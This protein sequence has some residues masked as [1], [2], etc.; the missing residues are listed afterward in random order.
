MKRIALT[1][2]LGALLP[3]SV[4]GQQ[5]PADLILLNG[6]IFTANSVQPYAQAVAIRGERIIA[7]GTSVDIKS[8]TGVKTRLI[9]L[10]G[11]VV[12]P[13]IND[14]HFHF[15]PDPKGYTLQF[16][17]MNP[18][19]KEAVDAIETAVKQT[20]QGTWIFGDLGL[21]EKPGPEA[22][23]FA[24]DRIAA[25]NPVLLR[26]DGHGY[27]IN[28]KAMPLLHIA[29][30]EPDPVGGSYER[31]EGSQRINGRLSEY[32]QWKPNRLLISQVSDEDIIRHL[33]ALADEAV[34]Y[35]ITSMQ[36]MSSMPV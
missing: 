24:L 30:E 6:K 3:L 27:I 9:D 22:T 14:A 34:R 33:R 20:P 35:G 11:R 12:I 1:V 23:R 2:L 18:S 10:Q 7:V 17:S 21:A 26:Y 15:M 4:L 5:A 16:K 31:V 36:I 13:G 8:L 25:N 28:S 29:E 19:W 32:A